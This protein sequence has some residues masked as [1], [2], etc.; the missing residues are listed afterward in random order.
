MSL[1]TLGLPRFTHRQVTKWVSRQQ[2]NDNFT[3]TLRTTNRSDNIG[4]GAVNRNRTPTRVG[5]ASTES[6]P[7]RDEE[8]FV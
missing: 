7:T 6:T 4:G 1:G 2:I 8:D 3:N 5:R